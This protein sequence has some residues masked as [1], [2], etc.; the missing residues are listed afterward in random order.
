M[1]GDETEG[2]HPSQSAYSDCRDSGIGR[3]GTAV[4]ARMERVKVARHS[5]VKSLEGMD[6][7]AESRNL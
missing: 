2:M 6:D 4:M 7:R 3:G 5:V 1:A